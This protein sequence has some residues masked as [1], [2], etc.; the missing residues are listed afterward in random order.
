MKKLKIYVIAS[1]R[2]KRMGYQ[3]EHVVLVN[4]THHNSILEITDTINHEVLHVLIEKAQKKISE[5]KHHF[6]I[7]KMLADWY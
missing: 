4:A 1:R 2:L 3:A 6:I 7:Y 5:K